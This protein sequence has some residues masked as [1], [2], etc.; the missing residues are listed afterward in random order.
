[1]MKNTISAM[2]SQN[3]DRPSPPIHSASARGRPIY[4][5]ASVRNCAP[6]R[7]SAIMQYRRVAPSSDCLKVDRLSDPCSADRISAPTTPTAAASVAVAM[8]V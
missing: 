7:I 4:P 8:P 1:M 2:I 5:M 6:A 3:C